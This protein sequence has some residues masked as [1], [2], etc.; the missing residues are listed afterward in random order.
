MERLYGL[1]LKGT[2]TSKLYTVSDYEVAISSIRLL[3]KVRI[4]NVRFELDSN[5]RLHVHAVMRV[6][7]RLPYLKSI[8][9]RGWHINTVLAYSEGWINYCSKEAGSIPEALEYRQSLYNWRKQPN[10]FEYIIA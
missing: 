7:K 9:G 3:G 8:L 5:Q 2:L 4:S 6:D 10:H 1:T